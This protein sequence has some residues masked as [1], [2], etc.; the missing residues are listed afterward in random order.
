[1]GCYTF[2]QARFTWLGPPERN[3]PTPTKDVVLLCVLHY[4]RLS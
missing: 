2:A 3:I 1:M 4:S